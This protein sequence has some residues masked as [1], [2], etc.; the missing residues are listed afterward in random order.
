MRGE[1][2]LSSPAL[3]VAVLLTLILPVFTGSASPDAMPFQILSV[4]I[5]DESG[6]VITQT[7]RGR[8]IFVD[9]LIK[10]VEVYG[11]RSFLLLASLRYGSP[12]RQLG[13]SGY[14]GSLAGGEQANPTPGF[15]IPADGPT[16]AYVIKVMVFSDWVALGGIVVA[17]PVEVSISVTG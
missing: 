9:V 16:G 13:L 14:K 3:C 11:S 2:H 17:E 15:Q 7:I 6:N 12:V 8:F 5:R 1:K 10:N 4:K